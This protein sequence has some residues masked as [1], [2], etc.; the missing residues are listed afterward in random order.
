LSAAGGRVWLAQ[1]MLHAKLAVIDDALALAGSANLDSRSLFLN[2][3][4]MLAFHQAADVRRFAACST[5]NAR[6]RTATSAA[7]SRAW[8]GDVAEGMLLGGSDFSWRP[9]VDSRGFGMARILRL[10]H[11]SLASH[12]AALSPARRYQSPKKNSLQNLKQSLFI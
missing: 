4:L 8:S 2:Y 7:H 6:P 3:E 11:W 12:L 1:G 5:R 10:P 9:S